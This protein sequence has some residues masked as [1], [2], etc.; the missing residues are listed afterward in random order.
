MTHYLFVAALLALALA[1]AFYLWYVLGSRRVAA[2]QMAA[3]GG[4]SV[5]AS[6][7][8]LEPSSGAG[9]YASLLAV[10]GLVFLTLWMVLRTIATGHGPFANMH[11]F[12]AAFS[13]G[14]VA[15]YLYVEFRYGVRTLGVVVLPLALVL[16]W[17]ASTVP[18][19]V[20]P[21]VPALQ[22]SLLLSIHV[23]VAILAYGT[24]AVSFGAAA[25]Y[26][27]QTHLPQERL[28]GRRLLD[29]IGYRCITLGFPLMALVIILGALWAHVAWGR[30]WGWDPKE[31]AS[32]VTWLIYGAYL[33]ARTLRGWRG[34]RSA[35][36]LI[37]GFGAVVFT[38]FGNLFFGGLHSYAGL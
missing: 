28:P 24:F 27:V 12:S 7:A 22:N 16:L 25:L 31:T 34:E 29:E 13:W 35:A 11:E 14:I 17:F 5:R 32:L 26:L 23:G 20:Q 18:S 10:N 4:P 19:D 21:L 36:L 2:V 6:A 8:M 1:T 37:V 30:Y 3:A 33:H 9:R 15:A 38:Y